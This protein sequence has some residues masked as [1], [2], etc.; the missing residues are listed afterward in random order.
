[1]GT[2]KA[3]GCGEREFFCRDGSYFASCAL[4]ASPL[5]LRFANLFCCYTQV[6]H[7]S[8]MLERANG[9]TYYDT[10]KRSRLALIE[11]DFN[12]I[13]FNAITYNNHKHAGGFP[14]HS[15]PRGSLGG[16]RGRRR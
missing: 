2:L 10:D 13:I 4:P 15:S 14:L 5:L 3:L 16:G 11:R 1:M 7:F 12:T 8:K 6:M 9:K